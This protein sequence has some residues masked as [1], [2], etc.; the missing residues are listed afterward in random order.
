MSNCKELE[1]S[2][3]N[4]MRAVCPGGFKLQEGKMVTESGISALDSLLDK[5]YRDTGFDFREYKR[6]TITRRLE[7]RLH[8]T[9]AKTY[10]DYMQFLDVHQEEYESLIDYLTIN[11][12][13]FFRNPYTFQQISSLVLPEL[14]SGKRAKGQQN[15]RFWSTACACGQEPYSIAILITD[16]LRNSLKDFD[17]S[18]YATDI[19]RYG[20]HRAK[21]GVYSPNEVVGLSPTTLANYFTRQ[22][23]DYVVNGA[24]RQMVRFSYFD[25]ASR[26]TPHFGSMDCIFCCNVLIYLQKSLQEKVL[27]MLYDSLAIPGYLILGEAETPTNNLDGK[28][29]CLDS[30]VK[31]YEKNGE[32]DNI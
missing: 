6:G 29:D 22:S 11:V 21:A 7:R 1:E 9:G 18:I 25:L 15:L 26:A 19:S 31:I 17:I 24:I 3:G 14:V 13:G 30:K 5:V 10:P 28:L 32:S 16:F 8:A 23:E 2:Y 27:E 12:S 4:A 20:L